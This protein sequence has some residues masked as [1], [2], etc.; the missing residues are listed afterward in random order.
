MKKQTSST[1]ESLEDLEREAQGPAK[2]A[3][4]FGFEAD[5]LAGIWKTV[6]SVF[7]RNQGDHWNLT[8]SEARNLGLMT[9]PLID[10][11]LPVVMTRYGAELA[12][13][14]SLT[15]IVISRMNHNVK[16]S[17]NNSNP[18]E[19]GIGQNNISIATAEEKAI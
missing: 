10:K 16:K 2:T 19:K 8:D 11:Y 18:R 14:S 3:T 6:F 13:A 4:A 12:L 17:G 15:M 7:A 5:Q 1:F 9:A